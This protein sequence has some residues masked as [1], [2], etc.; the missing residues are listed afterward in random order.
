MASC[1]DEDNVIGLRV[2][3][4]YVF[5]LDEGLVAFGECLIVE[6]VGFFGICQVVILHALLEVIDV[7][8]AG[9]QVAHELLDLPVSVWFRIVATEV[10]WYEFNGVEY[11]VR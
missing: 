3:F 1:N 9:R 7:I 4:Q 10:L 11:G 2:L 8:E 5:D 6:V